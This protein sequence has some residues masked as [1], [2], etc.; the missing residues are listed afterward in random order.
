MDIGPEKAGQIISQ[1]MGCEG[2]KSICAPKR[3]VNITELSQRM[4]VALVL[5]DQRRRLPRA[6]RHQP[7]IA[8][9]LA[10]IQRHPGHQRGKL[11]L[12]PPFEFR[13]LISAF[14]LQPLAFVLP[15]PGRHRPLGPAPKN[16]R[17]GETSAILTRALHRRTLEAT[18]PAGFDATFANREM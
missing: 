3:L 5:A 11:P 14:S 15:P 18:M 7:P 2:V 6:I 1:E 9:R 17:S 8:R 4:P 16:L 10:A 12:K 13:P